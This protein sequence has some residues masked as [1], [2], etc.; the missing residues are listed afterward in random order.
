MVPGPVL[1][2]SGPYTGALFVSFPAGMCWAAVALKAFCL[3]L[4]LSFAPCKPQV[5]Q[6]GGGGPAPLARGRLPLAFSRGSRRAAW[7]S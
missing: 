3:T 7:L 4:K 2:L 1:P 6:R 5:S